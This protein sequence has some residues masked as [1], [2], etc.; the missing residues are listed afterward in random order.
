VGS[1]NDTSMAISEENRDTIGNPDHQR[2]RGV[3]RH[4]GITLGSLISEL[5]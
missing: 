5:I 1:T 4:H 3:G 2:H